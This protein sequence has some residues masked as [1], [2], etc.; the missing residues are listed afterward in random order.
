MNS[1]LVGTTDTPCSIDQYPEASPTDITW[2]LNEISK[3][4]VKPISKQDILAVWCGI[5]PLV[6]SV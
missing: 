3:L 2:I 1:T 4:L 5:R 6:R